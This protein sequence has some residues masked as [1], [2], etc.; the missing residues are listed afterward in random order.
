MFT[1]ALGNGELLCLSDDCCW[2]RLGRRFEPNFNVRSASKFGVL[3]P[4]AGV[5]LKAGEGVLGLGVEPKFWNGI[6][7]G[8]DEE[9]LGGLLCFFFGLFLGFLEVGF[10]IIR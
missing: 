6:G 10:R 5:W 2:L 4:G 1:Y 7:F 8:F 3:R 9:D